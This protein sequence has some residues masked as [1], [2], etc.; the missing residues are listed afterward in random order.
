MVAQETIISRESKAFL[1]FNKPQVIGPDHR[2][3]VERF[4]ES[5]VSGHDKQ[6]GRGEESLSASGPGDERAEGAFS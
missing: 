5:L 1:S 2:T 6:I 4:E 3:K